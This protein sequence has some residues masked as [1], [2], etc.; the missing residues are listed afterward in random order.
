MIKRIKL[1]RNIG[2]FLSD[3]SAGSIDL[4]RLV[5]IHAENGRGKTTLAAVFRS[6]ASGDPELIHERRRLSSANPPHI[7]FVHG[8]I[9]SDVQFKDGAWTDQ[10]PNVRIF[11][12]AFVDENVY[13][14]LD[15][16]SQHRRNLH[17]L[18][19]G[20]QGVNLNR[21]HQVLVDRIAEHNRE[22]A[23]RA[24]KI[25]GSS[26]Y[27]LEVDEFCALP[28]IPEI[29]AAIAAVE[30]TLSA[31]QRQDEISRLQIFQNLHLPVF[32]VVRVK[33]LLSTGLSDLDRSAE[34]RVQTHVNSLNEH[35]EAWIAE[36]MKHVET[37]GDNCPFCGQNL[38]PSDLMT[39]YR[40]YFGEEYRELKLSISREIGSIERGHAT[41]QQTTFERSVRV[42]EQT[43]AKW[44]SFLQL[45][46]VSIETEGITNIWQSAAQALTEAL[47]E[48]QSTPLDQRQLNEDARTK[49]DEYEQC[50]NEI[51]DI[52]EKIAEWNDEISKFREGLDSVDMIQIETKLNRF[53]ATKLRH[54]A[55]I[56]STCADYLAEQ[57]T[58]S[59]TKS[60]RDRARTVL[61]EYRNDVFP[62]LQEGV[63]EYLGKFNAGYRVERLQP[64][65]TG[66]GSDCTYNL[67]I[68]NV[69]VEVAPQR[70]DHWRTIVPKYLECR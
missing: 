50:R 5:L 38:D 14:G 56:A 68:N 10:V 16:D 47:T 42:M 37:S 58:K 63:N 36:G 45:G 61:T 41:G 59:R 53:R 33:E 49:L 70:H 2:S 48:K 51:A 65:N 15:V 62:D 25:P 64:R 13:S 52:N 60:C 67:V 20:E 69:P 29:D 21:Q 39:H 23:K 4:K 54:S 9:A 18:I 55:E 44:S 28:Q 1:L 8:D 11:D 31:A 7:V 24:N 22:L 43:R 3:S 26:L 66:S 17:E 12:D 32:D 30:G 35:G 27:G 46:S 34:E 19:L 6:L 40:V 57:Q